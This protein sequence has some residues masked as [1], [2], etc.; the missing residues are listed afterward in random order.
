MVA[1]AA[2]RGAVDVRFAS[3]VQVVTVMI[4]VVLAAT[5]ADRVGVALQMLLVLWFV[6][7]EMRMRLAGMGWNGIRPTR[8]V[9]LAG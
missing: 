4:N 2:L 8:R 7:R 6:S 5:L 1:A 9:H 3:V